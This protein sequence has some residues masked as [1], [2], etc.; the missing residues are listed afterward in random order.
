MIDKHLNKTLYSMRHV[1]HVVSISL[2]IF[3]GVIAFQR[4]IA[5]FVFR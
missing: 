1:I 2:N 5:F 3:P 4:K